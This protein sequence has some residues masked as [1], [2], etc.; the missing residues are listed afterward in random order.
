MNLDHKLAQWQDGRLIDAARARKI[1][2]FE[3]GPSTPP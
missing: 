2:S 1:S 3:A